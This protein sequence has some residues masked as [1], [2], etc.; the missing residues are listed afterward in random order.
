MTED[1]AAPAERRGLRVSWKLVMGALAALTI[2]AAVTAVVIYKKY[3]QYDRIAALHLPPDTTAAVRVDVDKL[4]LYDPVRLHLLPLL[5]DSFG[6]ARGPSSLPSRR[7]RIRVRTGVDLAIGLRE[8][9][10]ARGPRWSDWVVVFSGKFPH[11]GVV[12]G[13]AKALSEEAAG[14]RLSADRRTLVGPGGQALGQADD[15]SV[16]LASSAARLGQALPRQDTYRRLGLDNQAAAAV[17]V[18]GELVRSYS[19]SPA[20]FVAPSLRELQ[21]VRQLSATVQLGH[22]LQATVQVQ[23]RPDRDAAAMKKP[24]GELLAGLVRLSALVPGQ[25]FAGE[26][27]ELGRATVSVAGPHQLDVRFSWQPEEVQR[28][29]ASLA[30]AVRRWDG[31]APRPAAPV[32]R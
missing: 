8:I 26:R 9:V 4:A 23:L 2:A 18:T 16:I 5:D 20:R 31:A 10:A 17:V 12:A 27:A 6:N 21:A 15:G 7:E 32:Q 25:D 1:D 19:S 30:R 3:V 28:G 22:P 29:A 24:L 11:S 14:W 13:V